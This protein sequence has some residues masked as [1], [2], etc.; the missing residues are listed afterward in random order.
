MNLKPF[1]IVLTVSDL[2]KS[3]T[4]YSQF[5][6]KK[7]KFVKKEDGR[8][9]ITLMPAGLDNFE[10]K[11]FSNPMA[12]PLAEGGDTQNYLRE[13]GTKYMS[14]LTEDIDAFYKK[15]KNKIN[16]LGEPKNGMTGCRYVFFK[17]PDNI[18]VE[19]YQKPEED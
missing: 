4:F 10:L 16:F 15:F 12:K 5:G 1:Q 3:I 6:F 19:V 2:E 8:T 17:D 13:V 11:L 14:L 9:R 7:G 18:L